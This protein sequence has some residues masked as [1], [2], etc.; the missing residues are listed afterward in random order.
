[1]AARMDVRTSDAKQPTTP[2]QPSRRTRRAEV[3]FRR[4]VTV[5]L[6]AVVVLG[7]AGA[8]GL[9]STTVSARGTTYELS[10]EH[11][12][13]TRPGLPTPF[14]I[15]VRGASGEPVTLAVT[16]AYL[17]AFE[18]P[19]PIPEASMSTTRGP[20]V[21]WEFDPPDGDLLEVTLGGRLSASASGILR[22]RVAVLDGGREL[23][24]VSFRSWVVP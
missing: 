7:A 5:L 12:A 17:E 4:V 10:V 11:A 1:M 6:L 18:A 14:A 9:R 21:V 8:F 19:S 2:E 3:A 23:V 15:E 13:V 20:M 24:A 22:G 16:S